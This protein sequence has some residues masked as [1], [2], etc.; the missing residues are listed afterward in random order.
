MEQAEVDGY[1]ACF[2]ND[3]SHPGGCCGAAGPSTGRRAA[4]VWGHGRGGG[5]S[6]RQVGSCCGPSGCA[7][8]L[9]RSTSSSAAGGAATAT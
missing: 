8:T 3:P 5:L 6:C 2:A 9:P 1:A 7:G 4:A